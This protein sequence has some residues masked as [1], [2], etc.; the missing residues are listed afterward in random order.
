[1]TLPEV[2]RFTRPAA[3]PPQVQRFDQPAD[4]AAPPRLAT[5]SNQ[6]APAPA[7]P[8]PAHDAGSI[9]VAAGIAHRAPD[10]SVVFG[11]SQS[12]EPAALQRA[13]EVDEMTVGTTP[14]APA[15]PA[16]EAAAPSSPAAAPAA[17][18]AAG[19]A[20]AAVGGTPNLD[21]LARRLYDPLAARIKAELRLDRERFGLVTD[22]RRP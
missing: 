10:G 17:A 13:V 4:T 20:A 18:A 3:A 22:L 5:A 14:A 6:S 11:T 7:P 9:A 21:E 15:P 8:A 2:Q 19:P 12:D 1:T 16:G